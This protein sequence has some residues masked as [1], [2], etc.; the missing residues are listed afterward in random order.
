MATRKARKVKYSTTP[1][2]PAT[3]L[4]KFINSFRPENFKEYW[5]SEAGAKR[6]AKIVGFGVLMILLVFL[7][8]A[9]DLPSPSKINAKINAQT[10]K[11][12]DRTHT[13]ILYEVLGDKNRS[14]I[15]FD[16]MPTNIK[17]ATIAVEDRNFYKHGAFSFLGI[18][19]A[20][21]VDVTLGSRAQGGS[22]ITQQYVKNALLSPERSFTR[23]IKELILS[24][25]IEAFYSKNDILKL[26]LNEIPYGGTAY[27][28]EAACR[29]YFGYHA[30]TNEELCAP[31]LTLDEAATLA[32]MARAP[33]Y[34]S[35]YG[36]HIDELTGR[37]Q[38]V[39]DLMV[40]QHYITKQQADEAKKIDTV[41]KMPKTPQYFANVTAP[42]FV[43]YVQEQLEAKYG[44]KAVTEGGLD[45]TTTL[46]LNRQKQIEDSVAKGIPNVKALGGSNVAMVTA[47]PKTGQVTGMVGS[48]KFQDEKFGAFNVAIANRQPGSSFKPLVYATAFAQNFGPGTTLY[49]VPTDFGG[50]YKPQNF[51]GISFGVL[52]MRQALGNSLNIPAVKTLYLAGI[53][54]A[55]DQA[56]RMGITTLQQ[57]AGNYGLSLTLGSGEVKL[58]DMVNAYQS[59]ANGGVHYSQVY[60]LKVQDA[61][62]SVLEEYKTPK[63]QNRVLDPQI[64][65][66]ISDILSDNPNRARVFGNLLAIPGHTV[67][68]KTGTTEHYNDAWTVGYTPSLVAG[69]WAGNNDNAPMS[70]AAAAISAPIWKDFMIKALAGSADEPFAK[71]TGLKQV[72]LDANTGKLA[73]DQT[74]NKRTDWFPSWYKP[75]AASDGGK[76][77]KVDKVSGKL[78]TSCTPDSATDTVTSSEIH[79][80][81]PPSDPAYYRWEPPVQ[82]LAASLGQ[83]GGA[84]P[85]ESDDVHHCDDVHPQVNLSAS[86][87]GGGNFH[88]SAVVTSG[89]FTANKLEFKLDDQIISTLAINGSTTYDFD[90]SVDS[91]GTHYFKATVTDAGLYQAEDSQTVTVTD[92]GS[93]GSFQGTT[94]TNG[95]FYPSHPTN[96]TFVWTTYTGATTYTVFI[97]RSGSGGF[98]PE[99]PTSSTSLTKTILLAGTYS[100]YVQS[101]SGPQTTTK[102][103]S[104]GP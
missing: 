32:A 96:V 84:L 51:G 68:V 11:L 36:Q 54:K 38:L 102:T 93:G 17:E 25:E 43:L 4:R 87:L 61:K 35:P 73:T 5:L 56:H 97:K 46:D 89:T 71:P 69:V 10:T 70:S 1:N 95:Q 94:P 85:T 28:V 88:L 90:T 2:A 57:P 77:A 65:W 8:F 75:P 79:A 24:T 81:I 58:V 104:V 92:A 103:F 83:Q 91:N 27:G 100:W 19:R 50:G 52:S 23:K 44:T 82:A 26:Y 101:S 18:L 45:V 64:A 40:D 47:D 39:L 80:E 37:K 7:Y 22:T 76:T 67:A 13:K 66:M 6:I 9:K 59:F 53:D 86:S 33:T 48:Y 74:K 62:G 98:T 31:N 60:W 30:K 49:D 63:T 15:S 78:A 21:V 72:T 12:W 14:I 55:L 41:A 34:Y 16:Q 3:K 29:T 42:H 20:A 99:A